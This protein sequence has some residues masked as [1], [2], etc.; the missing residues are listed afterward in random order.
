LR[1][2]GVHDQKSVPKT[3]QRPQFFSRSDEDRGDR[4]FEVK[5]PVIEIPTEDIDRL[6]S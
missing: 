1:R 6:W 3:G 4:D 5:R 2:V